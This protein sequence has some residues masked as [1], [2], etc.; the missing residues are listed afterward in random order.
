[1]SRGLKIHKIGKGPEIMTSKMT[2][3]MEEFESGQQEMQEKISRAT[4][5]VINLTKR[6]GITDDPG[7]PTSWKGGIDPSIMP[8]SDD[9]Y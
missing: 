4:K 3:R 6:K 8:N 7:E 2:S 9:L 5:M 1:M